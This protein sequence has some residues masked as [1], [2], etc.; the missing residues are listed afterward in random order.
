MD[1]RRVLAY[2]TGSVDEGLLLRNEYL[3]AKNRILNDQLK[4]RLR[5]TVAITFTHHPVDAWRTVT[6]TM[7]IKYLADDFAQANP[8]F[9]AL[10]GRSA[11]PGV[12]ARL[13][14]VQYPAYD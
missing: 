14:D 11:A 12:E 13:G 7:G 5:L 1:W 2:I 10:G 4:G 6:A 3:A 9:R 8:F